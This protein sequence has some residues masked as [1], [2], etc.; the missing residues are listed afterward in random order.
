MKHLKL[1]G[2]IVNGKDVAA[3]VKQVRG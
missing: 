3:A 2:A 1:S